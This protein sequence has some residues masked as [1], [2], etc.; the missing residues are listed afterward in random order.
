MFLY[1][2]AFA[3][4]FTIASR[5]SPRIFRNRPSITLV[6]CNSSNILPAASASEKAFLLPCWRRWLLRKTLQGLFFTGTANG[7]G[8]R[9]IAHAVARSIRTQEHDFRL[10]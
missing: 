9:L 1:W 3:A 2:T 8:T 6:V 10:G 5:K 4:C 7:L